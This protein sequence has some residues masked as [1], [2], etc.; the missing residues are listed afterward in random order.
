MNDVIETV[1]VTF[2]RTRAEDI[3]SAL[4]LSGHQERVI[5][6]SKDLAVGPINPPEPGARQEWIRDVLRCEPD[7]EPDEAEEPW[8][9]A[10]STAT[11][12]IYWVCMSD[13]AEQASFLEF[14]FRMNGRTFDVVNA[15]GLDFVTIRGIRTPWSLGLMSPEDIVA[16]GLYGR[17]RT[18]LPAEIAAASDLWSRLRR[19][20]TPLRIVRNGGLVSAPR[21]HFDTFLVEQ[22]PRDWEVAARLI[23][24]TMS[25]LSSVTPSHVVLFGRILALGKSQRLD[26]T[27]PGPGMRDYKV[28]R[29]DK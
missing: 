13:A 21:D 22:A 20:N 9:E 3:R 14:S 18:L 28:R 25:A 23:G 12:P 6:L 24:R 26:V 19:E 1:H 8:A 16:S 10:T 4:R 15:T 7:D 2:G 11:Y 27:G 17:R 29:P 5:G